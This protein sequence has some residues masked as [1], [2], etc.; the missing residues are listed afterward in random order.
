MELNH[1]KQLLEKYF[2]GNTSV[3]EE[4]LLKDFFRYRPVPAEMEA[5]KQ[6]FLYT[7]SESNMHIKNAALEQKLVDWID[8]QESGPKTFRINPWVYRLVGVAAFVAIIV[9]CYIT[10]SHPKNEVAIKD[11]YK[12][13]EIAYAETK[14]ALL[15][16]SQQLN[17]C[18]A[19]LGQMD[20]LNT[21]MNRLSSVSS[22]NNGL[23]QIEIVSKYYD[24]AKSENNKTK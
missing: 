19:P 23:E 15:Y 21:G 16:V 7:S 24:N 3:E 11:T 6:L 14:K 17:K 5:D 2:E 20:K 4:T 9:T 1:I 8:Q 18:T 22:L 10:I 13:P 12:S